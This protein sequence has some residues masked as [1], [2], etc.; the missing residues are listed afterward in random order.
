MGVRD[1]SVH[2]CECVEPFSIKALVA[3]LSE[4][5]YAKRWRGSIVRSS[6]MS[7]FVLPVDGSAL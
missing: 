2:V 5:F 3:R 4:I 6:H 1:R 7:T